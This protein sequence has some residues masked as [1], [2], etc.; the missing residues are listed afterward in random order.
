MTDPS[1]RR[2]DPWNAVAIV[3]VCL[4]VFALVLVVFGLL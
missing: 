4:L 2:P 1:G 3:A